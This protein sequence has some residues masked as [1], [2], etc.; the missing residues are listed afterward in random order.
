MPGTAAP[1]ALRTGSAAGGRLLVLAHGLAE[2][3]AGAGRVEAVPAAVGQRGGGGVEGTLGVG[4]GQQRPQREAGEQRSAAAPHGPG[5]AA[6][7]RD[8]MEW[9]RMGWDGDGMGRD[10]AA[11]GPRRDSAAEGTERRPLRPA[12][13]LPVPVLVP[14]PAGPARR[15]TPLRRPP[16]PFCRAAAGAGRAPPSSRPPSAA[17]PGPAGG[18]TKRSPPTPIVPSCCPPSGAAA[19]GERCPPR[20][21]APCPGPLLSPCPDVL[22]L[23]TGSLP[24]RASRCSGIRSPVASGS[25]QSP[26]LLCFIPEHQRDKGWS[27]PNAAPEGI[28]A[29]GDWQLSIMWLAPAWCVEH[30]PA[31]PAPAGRGTGKW[32]CFGALLRFWL[33]QNGGIPCLSLQTPGSPKAKC[34]SSFVA[35]KACLCLPAILPCRDPFCPAPQCPHHR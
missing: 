23:P 10:G 13:P 32:C 11:A 8:G 33:Q 25:S 28:C 2:L 22:S 7:E 16:G 5:P 18:D 31:N 17:D 14:S 19:P 15:H 1:G 34:I 35:L 20:G 12:R 4:E 30:P 3:R 21:L 26:A 6:A 27:A 9:D 29:A 24:P